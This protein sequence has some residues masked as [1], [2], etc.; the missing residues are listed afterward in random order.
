M[1][2]ADELVKQINADAIKD[3]KEEHRLQ[4]KYMRNT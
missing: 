4:L 1:A 3:M 2:E